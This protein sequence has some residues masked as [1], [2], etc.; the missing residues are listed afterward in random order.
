MYTITRRFFRPQKRCGSF[1]AEVLLL[2]LLTSMSDCSVLRKFEK[3]Q[4][5]VV[6]TY[7]DHRICDRKISK[8]DK[9]MP[10]FP[11]LFDGHVLPLEH[12]KYLI[13]EVSWDVWY[14]QACWPLSAFYSIALDADI[15]FLPS[16][17]E[18]HDI[19]L[20]L[21]ADYTALIFLTADASIPNYAGQIRLYM[22]AEPSWR[23]DAAKL[24]RIGAC[25]VILDN[26]IDVRTSTSWPFTY[27]YPVDLIKQYAGLDVKKQHTLYFGKHTV[28]GGEKYQLLRKIA[29]ERTW[30]FT[31]T[32]T[33]YMKMNEYLHLLGASFFVISLDDWAGAGQIHAE[34]AMLGTLSVAPCTKLMQRNLFHPSLC[35]DSVETAV[36]IISNL[37]DN[38]THYDEMIAYTRSKLAFIDMQQVFQFDDLINRMGCKINHSYV[39]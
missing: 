7:S 14:G 15:V 28:E 25:P 37:L 33:R 34:A 23:V 17:G 4:R 29:E 1:V 38:L 36:L 19:V 8:N 10:T 21:L 27:R 3:A 2:T 16:G 24:F 12:F 20:R 5:A 31:E 13:Y 35:A 39:V 11:F 9:T 30:N 26:Y 6:T 32:T 18:L 22:P